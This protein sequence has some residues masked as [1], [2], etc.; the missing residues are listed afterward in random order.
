MPRVSTPEGLRIR[1][2]LDEGPI[3]RH[4]LQTE[5]ERCISH[6]RALAHV[7]SQIR[8][9][10]VTSPYR[11]I[12]EQVAAGQRSKARQTIYYAIRYGWAKETIDANGEKWLSWA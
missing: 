1:E 4:Q 6:H 2:L 11:P 7:Q 10:G 3:K 9:Q 12:E 8:N 5:L